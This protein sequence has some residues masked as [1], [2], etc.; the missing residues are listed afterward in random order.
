MIS[1]FF[2]SN[3]I[4]TNECLKNQS[5]VK[6]FLKNNKKRL[7]FTPFSISINGTSSGKTIAGASITTSQPLFIL[8]EIAWE[9]V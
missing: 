7:T 9:T 8:F 2:L 4:I 1:P 5:C 3:T 6:L